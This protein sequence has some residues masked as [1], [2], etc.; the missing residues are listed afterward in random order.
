VVV[1]TVPSVLTFFAS[2]GEDILLRCGELLEVLVA[3][4]AMA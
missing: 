1:E 3:T 4:A 2:F